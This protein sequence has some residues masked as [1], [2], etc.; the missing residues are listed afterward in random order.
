[1]F[2]RRNP[3][4][5]V[6]EPT[7]SVTTWSTGTGNRSSATAVAIDRAGRI[8]AFGSEA[9][10]AV[11]RRGSDLQ[12]V[13][14]FTHGSVHSEA[15]A[16]AYLRWIVDQAGCRRNVLVVPVLSTIDHA[17]LAD[18]W[19]LAAARVRLRSLAL[20]RPVAAAEETGLDLDDGA[21]MMVDV[22]GG[23]V[24]VT[25][26]DRGEVLVTRRCSTTEPA[27][28]AAV[29]RSTL[30]QVDPDLEQDIVQTGLT[31]MGEPAAV[32]WV[33]SLERR[34]PL[35][36]RP[37]AVSEQAILDGARRTVAGLRP[38]LGALVSPGPRRAVRA[39][40]AGYGY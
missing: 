25:V 37:G 35:S 7:A 29:V 20:T 14:P 5:I 38:Y 33:R 8:M 28:V 34:L 32:D 31:L 36:L 16:G 15:L 13:T 10:L 24:E 21:R 4:V 22:V 17:S 9:V 40:P 26:V 6:L 1:M 2:L 3:D 11:A 18:R 23:S 12:L 27:D 30:V 39:A 19:R